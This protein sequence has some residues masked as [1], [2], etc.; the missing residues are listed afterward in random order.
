M[1][2]GIQFDTRE[3]RQVMELYAKATKKDEADIINRTARNF[4]IKALMYT[5]SAEP[6][7]IAGQLKSLDSN[8]FIALVFKILRGKSRRGTALLVRP[9]GGRGKSSTDTMAIAMQKF[10][11]HR[12][13]TG[14][15]IKRGWNK[16][17]QEFGAG[18]AK[19]RGSY[20]GSKKSYGKKA[21]ERKSEAVFENAAEGSFGVADDAV[22]RALDAVASDM[23]DYAYRVM[24]GTAK[25]FS[26]RR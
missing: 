7:K 21:T 26:A 12:M 18:F 5:P 4:A 8:T 2:T 6:G 15:Y 17:A 16:V 9:K 10:I 1:K 19:I 3:L 24:Q 11:R 23:R 22:Q 14:K 25:K 13:N 20:P